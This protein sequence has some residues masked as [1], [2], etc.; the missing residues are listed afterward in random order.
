M[1]DFRSAWG[2]W[3]IGIAIAGVLVSSRD[4]ALA[5]SN[6]V[7]DNTL[8]TENSTLT[9]N[10][11][12]QPIEVITGGAIRGQ[13]LFHSF[14]QFNISEGRGAYFFS[15]SAE[16]QN[17]L[18]RV[19]GS[20]RSEILG[21][22]GT[23]GN[24]NPNLF[25]INPNGIVFGKN[26]SLNVDGSFVATT[27]NG[28]QF[29]NLGIFSANV[30]EVPPLLTVNSSAFL[31]NQLNP[32][33]IVNQS[34][35]PAGINPA[36]QNVT[37]LRVP[38][39]KSLLLVGGNIN[40]DGGSLRAYS[41][42][43]EL[44][45]LASPGVIGINVIDNTFSLSVNNETPRADV[46]LTN[47]AEVNVR[48]A[49]GGS[50]AINAQN[51][52]LGGESKVRAG[53]DTG[54]GVPQSKAG[55]IDINATGKTTLTDASF[56]A[57][58]P[59]SASIGK[60][61]NI[62]ITTGSLL[63]FD[64]SA[65]NTSNS[66]KGDAG[67]IN[68][69]IRDRLTVAGVDPDGFGSGI[70]SGVQSQAL[71]N[72]GNINIAAGSVSLTDGAFLDA[73]T[74]GRGSAG[75]I[76]MQAKDSI[77][78]SNS[79][80]S[81]NVESGGDGKVGNINIAASSLTLKDGARL[82]TA[83]RRSDSYLP[84][85]RGVT[86]NIN[87]D[88][89]GE[90]NITGQKNGLRSGIFSFVEFGAEGNGS[91]INIKSGSLSLTDGALLNVSTFG[92][93]DAGSISIQAKDSVLL[94]DSIIFGNVEAGGDGNVGSINVAAS[95]LTLKDGAQLQ[96]LLRSADLELNLPGG[97]GNTGNINI[98]VFGEVNI[99]G[100]K[101][102]LR[103]GIFSFVDTNAIGNSGNIDIRS[104]SLSLIDN[105]R[106]SAG[107]FGKGNAGNILL[108]VADSVSLQNSG[109]D[110]SV[111]GEQAVGKGGDIN[112]QAR[113]V[114]LIQGS[115]LNSQVQGE[116]NAG[117][118]TINARET[119]ALDGKND[120][121]FSGIYS[122]VDF[123]GQGKAGDIAIA[124]GSLF[125]SNGA[126]LSASTFGF[127]D[128][129]NL[130]IRASELIELIG[131][132]S[133][134]QF[135]SGLST[136]VGVAAVGNGGSLNIETRRLSIKGS[137]RVTA[138]T[139]GKGNAGNVNIDAS[140]T[141]FLDASGSGNGL[142][143]GVFSSVGSGAIGNGGSI[144]IAVG[145]LSLIS[146][147]QLSSASRGQGSAGN[148]AINA[149]GRVNANN[150]SI[151]ADAVEFT[152]GAINITARD[153][154]L[155]GNSDIKTSVFSGKGGG[156][157]IFLTANSIVALDDSDIF[158]LSLDGVGGNITLNTRVFFG[159]RYYR[160]VPPG[161]DPS[162]LDGNDRTDINASGIVSGVPDLSYIQDNLVE[163]SQNPVDTNALIA[164]SCIA[165]S[166][167]SEG[168][169]TITG[170]G[171]LPNRPGDAWV[172][173]YP[174]GDVRNVLPENA[175][176]PWQKGDPIVEPNGVYKLSSL[177]LVLSR[178]CLKH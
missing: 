152:G 67:N 122:A 74:S 64:G 3:F 61:G 92:K 164:N 117:N 135:A 87:I 5:Q 109:I 107:N 121:V 145:S 81:G 124:T 9:P 85:G 12:G 35:A 162:T 169:F 112:I 151:F 15:P 98:A 114:S 63:V 161:T 27:A 21:V 41:G 137:A 143:G 91:D 103:S 65:L 24:S 153:I 154:R 83:L 144:N 34:V 68:L 59:Q 29:G 31:F 46:S 44:A 110:S 71:G 62:N 120:R 167:K 147:S 160:P 105:A 173:S 60:G 84:A 70:F 174:T 140:D 95:S 43:I 101:N 131:T 156:G 132:S 138:E 22:L 54:L 75:N 33:A 93:G 146:N 17:I 16:I 52:T 50:I 125:L 99:A 26:A 19:T 73:S 126:Q 134:G 111:G 77:L 133:D 66:G 10:F 89:F 49:D 88:V 51:L 30:P 28:V 13:N 14:Q 79:L 11:N 141:I 171:G 86:G 175:S 94:S 20:E 118:I 150:G 102:G 100:E 168:T 113:S 170:T 149:F 72:G 139:L 136:Q 166:G 115:Q 176:R 2:C 38:D 78:L 1:P 148:I 106:V 4:C 163:L 130:N 40:I 6:I 177:K 178:E 128:A 56:I 123:T 42:R 8:N 158:A 25:L 45:G 36:G 47:A 57:N 142:F 104:G 23:F 90:V 155:R 55:D 159:F 82:S 53:I 129:G 69:N 97:R 39:G 119:V 80:I 165:R 58:V 157:S 96:I 76:F 116:G 172:S 32:K 48:G 127:G 7:P 18:A 37:G 108:K